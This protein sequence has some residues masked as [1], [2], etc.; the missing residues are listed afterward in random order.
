MNKKRPRNPSGLFVLE[1]N[2]LG[3]DRD[4]RGADLHF[5]ASQISGVSE[6]T[7][8]RIW[9]GAARAAAARLGAV[10]NGQRFVAARTV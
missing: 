8:G 3:P 10:P 9:N 4:G 2:R 6:A 1:E 5:F 7:I